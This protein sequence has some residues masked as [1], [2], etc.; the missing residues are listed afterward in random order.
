M[1]CCRDDG[2]ILSENRDLDHCQCG[3]EPEDDRA[4]PGDVHGHRVQSGAAEDVPLLR[5]LPLR[6][7]VHGRA[8]RLGHRYAQCAT[9]QY[10]TEPIF[11]QSC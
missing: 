3:G 2:D 8:R 5:R 1:R 6:T 7:H 4:R 10:L 11:S 9:S